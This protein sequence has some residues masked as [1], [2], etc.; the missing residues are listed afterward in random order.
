[1][2]IWVGVGVVVFACFV[3]ER[4]FNRELSRRDDAIDR[5]SERVKKLEIG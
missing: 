2:W 4:K 3:L 1:V 5:L